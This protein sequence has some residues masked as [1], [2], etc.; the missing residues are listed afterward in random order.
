MLA[1]GSNFEAPRYT[2][3]NPVST[4][5]LHAAIQNTGIMKKNDGETTI[6]PGMVDA[7]KEEAG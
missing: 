1:T 5:T 6:G 7:I 2:A 3:F 4:V